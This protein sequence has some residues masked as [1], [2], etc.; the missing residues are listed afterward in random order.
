MVSV[1]QEMV[2]R[3]LVNVLDWPDG[4][5]LK[6][7]CKSCCFVHLAAQLLSAARLASAAWDLPAMMDRWPD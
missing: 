5:D 1:P 6:V 7:L 3:W 2:H 4:W